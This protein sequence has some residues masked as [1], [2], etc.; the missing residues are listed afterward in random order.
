MFQKELTLI[1]Q[2]RQENVCFVITGILKMLQILN[3]MC[4]KCHNLLMTAFELENIAILNVK[5]VDYRCILWGISKNDAV[6]IRNNSV[7]K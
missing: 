3:R 4:N 2:V 6:N 5:G 1:K 7:R